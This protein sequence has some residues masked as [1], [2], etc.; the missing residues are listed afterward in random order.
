[1]SARTSARVG[2]LV[3]KIPLTADVTT[4]VP[5]ARTPRM[6]MQR[7]SALTRTMTPSG[8]RAV[9][10][11]SAIVLVRRSCNCSRPATVWTNR[12]ILDN[13]VILPCLE[14]MYAT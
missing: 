13:P 12:A 9:T 14:G 5:G 8:W 7:C 11:V 6:V 10:R 2:A 3:L 4:S 1:M